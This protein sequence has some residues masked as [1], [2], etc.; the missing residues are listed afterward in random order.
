MNME[1]GTLLIS[2][3]AAFALAGTVFM[4]RIVHYLKSRGERISFFLLR[5][6]WFQYMSRYS[7]LTIKDTG[8]TGSDLKWYRISMVAALLFIIAG[9]LLLNN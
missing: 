6:R 4:V 5:L 2:V 1:T 9:A 8:E 7:E 3:G